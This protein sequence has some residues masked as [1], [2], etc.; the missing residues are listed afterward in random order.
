[1]KFQ[2]NKRLGDGTSDTMQLI[3]AVM[4]TSNTMVGSALLTLPFVFSRLGFMLTLPVALIAFTFSYYG[5]Q[6]IVD[7]AHHTQSRTMRGMVTGIFGKPAATVIDISMVV[8]YGG[9]LVSYVS[10]AGDYL[11]TFI[12]AISHLRDEEVD[13]RLVKI[14]LLV[15]L[16]PLTAMGSPDALSKMSAFAI[17]FIVVTVISVCIFFFISLAQKTGLQ[18]LVPYTDGRGMTKGIY[19]YS[20]SDLEYSRLYLPMHTATNR[21][22][23]EF[24]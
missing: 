4:T 15:V 11:K 12:L 23:A 24:V 5:F 8:M 7:A 19:Q 20:I 18:M 13:V 22:I 1:M 14:G 3:G 2:G 9:F 6:A 21:V 17:I 16:A 10:I